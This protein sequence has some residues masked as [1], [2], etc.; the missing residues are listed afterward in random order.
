MKIA[1]SA[2]S[3]FTLFF[4]I[5]VFFRNIFSVGNNELTDYIFV[6]LLFGILMAS[7]PKLLEFI[8]VKETPGALVLIGVVAT[9]MFYFIGYYVFDLFVFADGTRAI[10]LNNTTKFI[11]VEDK[12]FG[13]IV[14]SLFSSLFSVILSI[15]NAKAKK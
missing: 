6:G 7:T 14:I 12:T 9:F 5:M 15:L 4:F 13:L 3:N 8:K 10:M 2:L 1:N 11:T